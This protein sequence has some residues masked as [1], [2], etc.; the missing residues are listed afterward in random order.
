MGVVTQLAIEN[1]VPPFVEIRGKFDIEVWGPEGVNA[2]KGALMSAE[3]CAEGLEEV[4]L[5]C[6]YDGAPHYRVDIRAPDYPSAESVWEA[7][8][9]AATESIGFVEGSIAI[10]R[11]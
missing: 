6:H 9:K 5:T 7:A 10:E 1:I 2:I 4:V 11:L 8:Q 3:A